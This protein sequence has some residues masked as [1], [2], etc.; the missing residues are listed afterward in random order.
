MSKEFQE[1]R[2]QSDDGLSLFA[3]NWTCSGS[4]AQPLLCLA[5]L[6]R[7]SNDFDEFARTL[8]QDA[9][10]PVQVIAMDYR[11][12]GQSDYDLKNTNYSFERELKD[13]VAGLDALQIE[14]FDILGTSRGGIHAIIMSTFYPN[15]VGKVILNDIGPDISKEGLQRINEYI[16]IPVDFS[17][18]NEAASHLKKLFSEQFPLMTDLDWIEEV[19]RTYKISEGQIVLNYDPNLRQSFIEQSDKNSNVDL[20]AL[21]KGLASK[22]LM[23]IHGVLSNILTKQTIEKMNQEHPNL[24]VVQVQ[25]QGHPPQLRDTETQE[26]IKSFLVG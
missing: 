17:N 1:F 10:N 6:T 16:G 22:E 26:K 19:K 3:K 21:F 5:G 14:T 24:Q 9:T 4:N 7:N 8:S 23:V 18:Q 25:E 13:I 2:W 12:R 20:W 11:G 15:R